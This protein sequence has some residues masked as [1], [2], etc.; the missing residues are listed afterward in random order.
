[1]KLSSDLLPTK[2]STS[3]NFP[4]K[5][6]SFQY[7]LKT[8]TPSSYSKDN[9]NNTSKIFSL[10]LEQRENYKLKSQEHSDNHSDHSDHHADV[11]W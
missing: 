4:S 9:N 1:M 10:F 2:Q 3:Q 11:K 6:E 5:V 7:Q 8:F